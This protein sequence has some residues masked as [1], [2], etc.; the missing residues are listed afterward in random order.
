MDFLFLHFLLYKFFFTVL[1]LLVSMFRNNTLI[2]VFQS[3]LG[4]MA[5][6]LSTHRTYGVGAVT[7]VNIIS[8]GQKSSYYCTCR[9]S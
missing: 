3:V 4:N 8:T 9:N 6:G 7:E 1:K 5:Q 2:T